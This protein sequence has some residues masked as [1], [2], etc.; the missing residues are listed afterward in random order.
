MRRLFVMAVAAVLWCVSTG[1]AEA[2]CSNGIEAWIYGELSGTGGNT[3]GEANTKTKPGYPGCFQGRWQTELWFH[4]TTFTPSCFY[5]AAWNG[6]ACVALSPNVEPSYAALAGIYRQRYGCLELRSKHWN[7]LT[8][9]PWVLVHQDMSLACGGEPPPP[10]DE[11]CEYVWSEEFQTWECNSPILLPVGNSRVKRADYNLTS[12]DDGVVFDLD[13]DGLAEQTAWTR[14]NTD[15]GFLALDR[16]DNGIIDNG[17]EL[18]GDSTHA[19]ARNG[20]AA[21]KVDAG[22]NRGHIDDTSPLYEKLVIWVDRNHNGISEQEEIEPFSKYYTEIGLSYEI[23]T[24][25]DR[26]GNAFYFKGNATVRTGI[27][28][29]RPRN[30]QEELP[31]VIDVYDV[32]FVTR[33]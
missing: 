12:V 26:H 21:L 13:G 31:R 17:K 9:S 24:M 25:K 30:R 16:N 4:G 11:Y 27:G 20:F 3:S 28:R 14:Q 8:A 29:N 18:F 1:R 22:P 10:P 5:G 15:V 6:Y 23:D 19:N 33:R 7:V 32:Y 2:Q